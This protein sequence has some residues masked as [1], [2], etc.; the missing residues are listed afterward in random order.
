MFAND[1]RMSRD[2]D[3]YLTTPPEIDDEPTDDGWCEFDEPAP[4]VVVPA[5]VPYDLDAPDSE[6]HDKPITSEQMARDVLMSKRA[7]ITQQGALQITAESASADGETVNVSIWNTVTCFDFVIPLITTV[8]DRYLN[9]FASLTGG[10]WRVY[11]PDEPDG[12]PLY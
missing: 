5:A 11:C 4:V 8:V 3:R 7:L 6:W 12:A 1:S 2:L 10:S 9:S